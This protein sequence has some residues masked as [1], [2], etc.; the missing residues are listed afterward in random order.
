MR[1]FVLL[2]N[3]CMNSLI[4]VLPKRSYGWLASL[5]SSVLFGVWCYQLKWVLFRVNIVVQLCHCLCVCVC[6]VVFAR[7]V[8]HRIP[9]VLTMWVACMSSEY[10]HCCIWLWM[11]LCIKVQRWLV[12]SVA[13]LSTHTRT[14]HDRHVHCTKG[15]Y[16]LFL[17]ECVQNSVFTFL[18]RAYLCLI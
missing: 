15:R 12:V 6:C 11:W 8:V 1:V 2:E 13:H 9:A 18:K 3:T 16:R 7:R 10:V 4:I 5:F 17:W 14:V